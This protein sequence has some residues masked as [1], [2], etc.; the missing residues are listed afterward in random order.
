ML[1]LCRDYIVYG[2]PVSSR[3]LHERHA[4]TWSPAT[5]RNELKC[6]EDAGFLRQ[7]HS[8]S[9]R[10]PTAE[11][12]QFFIEN[13][14]DRDEPAPEL[15]RIIESSIPS[16]GSTAHRLRTTT[17]VLSE[18]SGC[19]AI[20]FFGQRRPRV[21]R[22]VEL[23]ELGPGR[24]LAVSTSEDGARVVRRVEL[25]QADSAP[26]AP[27]REQLRSLLVGRTVSEAREHLQALL[28]D[29]R[30]RVDAVVALAVRLGLVLCGGY[31]L[32][33]LWLR[34]AGQPSLAVVGDA[35]LPD[36]ARTLEVLED[37]QRLAYLL[38]QLFPEG[39]EAPEVRVG[40]DLGA[41][42]A[43]PGSRILSLVGCRVPPQVARAASGAETG[44]LALLGPTRMDYPRL[45]PLVEYAARAMAA[46]A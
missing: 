43:E 15:L 33:P 18:I 39:S 10:I 3:A 36:L 35:A 38:C 25:G 16:S 11:G 8:A 17:R 44:V 7:P 27:V 9:G 26:F 34:V 31:A 22:E 2:Q 37:Y 41:T 20:A 28:E 19:V 24:G 13:L 1:A 29:E 46:R 4:L 42:V 6:L 14:P 40:V 45:I 5:I 30:A 21:L 12:L 23:I 32:D